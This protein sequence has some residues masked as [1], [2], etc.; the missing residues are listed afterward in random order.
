M[1]NFWGFIFM[2]KY[3]FEFKLKIVQQYLEGKVGYKALGHIHSISYR[4]IAKWVKL[5]QQHG[6]EGLVKHHTN[7]SVEF[8]LSVLKKILEEHWSVNQASAYFN[9]PAP[10]SV[11][12]W[13]RL[14]NQDGVSALDPKPKGRRPVKRTANDIQTLLK[15]PIN[16]LSHEELLQRV[17]YVEVENAYLKKLEALAQQKTLANKTRSK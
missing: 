17:H 13:V 10:S 2:S 9:I 8:K 15:K 1:S 3:S 16:E 7:Y 6:S 5:Y 14:Y 12:S 11:L 4:H